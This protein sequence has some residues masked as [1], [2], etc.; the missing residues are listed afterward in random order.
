MGHGR[1]LPV[2]EGIDVRLAHPLPGKQAE[3]HTAHHPFDK[4]S[5]LRCS[6]LKIGTITSWGR[7]TVCRKVSYA[8]RV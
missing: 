6:N 1:R 3:G 2:I 8:S 5:W 7:G 4:L